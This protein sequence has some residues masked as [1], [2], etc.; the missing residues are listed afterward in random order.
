MKRVFSLLSSVAKQAVVVVSFVGAA[1]GA[2]VRNVPGPAVGRAPPATDCGDI[3]DPDDTCPLVDGCP[4]D[5]RSESAGESADGCPAPSGIPALLLCSAD[6]AHL[7]RL[8]EEMQRRQS[9]TLLLVE[10]AVPGCAEAI[11][12]QLT[13]RGVASGRLTARTAGA[14]DGCA[15]WAHFKVAAWAGHACVERK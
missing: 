7:A 11:R 10:A 8:A 6:E 5:P 14:D 13:R 3:P 2:S 9:L 1:C 4:N 12:D 15:P